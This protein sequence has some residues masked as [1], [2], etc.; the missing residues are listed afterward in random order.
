[1]SFLPSLS[2]TFLQIILFNNDFVGLFLTKKTKLFIFEYAQF[3]QDCDDDN[4]IDG[5][6]PTDNN[7]LID[8]ENEKTMLLGRGAQQPK[9]NDLYSGY[10]FLQFSLHFS[11]ELL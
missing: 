3:S 9:G 4:D 10:E 8:E 11:F 5:A 1:M 2:I 7:Q 6:G